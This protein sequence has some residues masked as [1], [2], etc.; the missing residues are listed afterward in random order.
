MEQFHNIR[1]TVSKIMIRY[2]C[3]L[4]QAFAN[5]QL[6]SS[7]LPTREI[8]GESVLPFYWLDAYEDHYNQ[9]GTVFLFGKVWVSDIQTFVR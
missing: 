4:L 7:S 3:F 5:V 8:G 6:D 9:P 2:F 1:R